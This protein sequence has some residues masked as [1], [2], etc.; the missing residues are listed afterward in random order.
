MVDQLPGLAGRDIGSES[1]ETNRARQARHALASAAEAGAA[2]P[3]S[4][5]EGGITPY[6]L[7]DYHEPL[8]L[9]V[10]CPDPSP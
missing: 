10:A 1:S 9:L 5:E 8:V 3:P 4:I 2:L 6:D 7:T